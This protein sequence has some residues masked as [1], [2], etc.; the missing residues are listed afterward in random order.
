MRQARLA[1]LGAGRLDAV[2]A[3]IA[4]MTGTAGK[5]AQIDWEFARTLR[6]DHPL[7]VGLSAA[8]G[9]NSAALDALFTQAAAI[10]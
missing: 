4:G 3:A 5:A 7:T 1:L 2:E 8:L 9:L 6:R 10:E